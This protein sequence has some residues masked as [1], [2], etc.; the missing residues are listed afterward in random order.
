MPTDVPLIARL[1]IR[2]KLQSTHTCT[3]D[4]PDPPAGA[5][6]ALSSP[7]W[8][9]APFSLLSPCATRDAPLFITARRSSVDTNAPRQ[10][11]GWRP[12][13]AQ[14]ADQHGRENTHPIAKPTFAITANIDTTSSATKYAQYIHQSI[15]SPPSATLLGALKHSEELATIPGLTPT[16][17]K[18]HLP[19]STATNKGHMRQH[20]SNTAST[21]NNQ[22]NIEAKHAK[23]D[24]MFPQQEICAM[25]DV[26][27]FAALANT[28]TGSMYTDIT[29]ALPVRLFKSMQFIFV[30]YVYDLS[31]NIV[32]AM[33]SHTDASMVTAFIE[34]ITTPKTGGYHPSMFCHSREVH[35]V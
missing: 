12:L 14:T 20:R 32:C 29:S 31:T 21:Q 10:A 24:H 17:I 3:L 23:I 27:C 26:F 1:P 9:S 18:N 34:V 25:Q 6:A 22:N 13:R 30:A 4:L 35:Q 19:L 7:A 8:H 15:C 16:L 33:P 28:I 11:C 5:Q 2:D